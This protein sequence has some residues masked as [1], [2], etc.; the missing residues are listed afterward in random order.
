MGGVAAGKKKI[1]DTSERETVIRRNPES[2]GEDGRGTNDS[3][4]LEKIYSSCT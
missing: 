3:I 2:C 4:M 1:K